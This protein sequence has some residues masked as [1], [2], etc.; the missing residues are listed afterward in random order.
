[1]ISVILC[2]RPTTKGYDDKDTY[3]LPSQ[4]F[5]PSRPP[6]VQLGARSREEVRRYTTALDFF[7]LFFT[8]EMV[9]QLCDFTNARAHDEIKASS[10]Y[11]TADGLWTDVTVLEMYR[12]IGLL[13]YMSIV[14]A[15]TVERYVNMIVSMFIF[16]I[17]LIVVVNQLVTLL[18]VNN[19]LI[20]NTASI[21][22]PLNLI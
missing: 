7:K 12:F 16:I 22:V 17:L 1:M 4:T 11:S 21:I 2:C 9:S 20:N 14:Q 3:K 10:D 6:G 8:F 5:K 19:S 13:M 18:L 15:S